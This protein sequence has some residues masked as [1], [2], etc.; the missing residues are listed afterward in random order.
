TVMAIQEN[1]VL[2]RQFATALEQ[3]L[4]DPSPSVALAA[5][6]TLCRLEQP[7]NALPVIE[8]YL[9]MQDEPWVVLQAAMVA[10]RIGTQAKPLV[11]V[12]QQEFEH[13]QGDVWGRYKSWVYP[14][15]IGFAFDQTLI[16]CGVP[17]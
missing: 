14:M 17:L 9:K 4:S 3:A 15:F 5:A 16:N 13:Y 7:G 8:K 11:P 6:E 1:E 2:A 12:I 10:R